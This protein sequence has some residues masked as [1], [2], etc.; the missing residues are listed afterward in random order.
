MFLGFFFFKFSWHKY[1]LK[2]FILIYLQTLITILEIKKNP[3]KQIKQL[4]SEILPFP[5][6][7]PTFN[8]L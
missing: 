2:N 6:H 1:I 3:V 5:T 7:L 8:N 4:N